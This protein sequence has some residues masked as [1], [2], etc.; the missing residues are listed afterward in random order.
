ML[1]VNAYASYCGRE[2][3]LSFRDVPPNYETRDYSLNINVNLQFI[4]GETFEEYVNRVANNSSFVIEVYKFLKL[5][6][7]KYIIG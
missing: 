4:E 5:A 6:D 2:C 3:H 1:P 7:P